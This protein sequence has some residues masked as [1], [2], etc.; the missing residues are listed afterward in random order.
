[1]FH[2]EILLQTRTSEM[3]RKTVTITFCTYGCI[4]RY[5]VGSSIFIFLYKYVCRQFV[6][7]IMKN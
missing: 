1:M 6:N 7:L 3:V 4:Y 5:S 2:I